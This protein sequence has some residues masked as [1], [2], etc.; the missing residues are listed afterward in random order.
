LARFVP[1]QLG[2][3]LA[4][5]V[6]DVFFLLSPRYRNVVSNNLKRVTGFEQDER[7]LRRN[8]RSVFKNVIKNYFDLARLSRL[9]LE[10][11]EEN[12]TI[13]GWHH[14]VETVANAKGAIIATAHLGNFDHTARI[15]AILIIL[16]EFCHYVAL[17]WRFLLRLLIPRLFCAILPYCD[18]E[19]G[20]ES[21]R[22]APAD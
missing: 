21:C 15:W 16:R 2:Y 19:T 10:S 20:A 22:L 8:V 11:L 13:E 12:V 1:I 18:R 5:R 6:G 9:K 7:T 4:E 17:K 3:F 14:L